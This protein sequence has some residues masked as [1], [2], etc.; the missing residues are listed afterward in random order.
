MKLLDWLIDLIINRAKRTPYFHLEGYMERYWLIKP[1]PKRWFFKD[2]SIRIHRILRS[3]TDDC[4]HDHPW[5]SMSI[6]IYFSVPLLGNET[7][8][9]RQHYKVS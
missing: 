9:L 5:A 7:S 8:L 1:N 3:D 2:F 6:I 4:F